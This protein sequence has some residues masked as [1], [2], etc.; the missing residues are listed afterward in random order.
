MGEMTLRNGIARPKNVAGRHVTEGK[1]KLTS[2]HTHTQEKSI[3]IQLGDHWQYSIP[4]PR[5]TNASFSHMCTRSPSRSSRFWLT[6]P[7]SPRAKQ[8]RDGEK[9]KHTQAND[10]FTTSQTSVYRSGRGQC[11]KRKTAEEVKRASFRALWRRLVAEGGTAALH[12]SIV[13]NAALVRYLLALIC[14]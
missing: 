14:S 10:K 3:Q 1:R 8:P 6:F 13:L 11:R 2:T 5:H 4:Q 12:Y 7:C 9:Q